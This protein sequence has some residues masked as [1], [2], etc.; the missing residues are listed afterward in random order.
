M[1]YEDDKLS[2]KHIYTAFSDFKGAFRG[3]D[4]RILFKIMRELGFP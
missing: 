3:M 4:H 1:M 2:R